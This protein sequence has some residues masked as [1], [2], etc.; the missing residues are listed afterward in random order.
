M[1]VRHYQINVLRI[2][3]CSNVASRQIFLE[4]QVRE[5]V[6]VITYVLQQT[7]TEAQGIQELFGCSDG[8]SLFLVPSFSLQVHSEL[9]NQFFSGC[10]RTL[11]LVVDEVG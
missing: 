10:A 5:A 8:S 11:F 7:G 4:S 1:Q 3:P 6:P 9:T 2:R